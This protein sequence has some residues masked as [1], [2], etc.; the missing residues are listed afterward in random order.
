VKKAIFNLNAARLYRL[1][2]EK[3]VEGSGNTIQTLKVK[4]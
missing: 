1:N 4:G 2:A 3:L